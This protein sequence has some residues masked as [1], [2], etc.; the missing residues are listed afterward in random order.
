MVW[1]SILRTKEKIRRALKSFE[2]RRIEKQII[3]EKGYDILKQVH[4]S[5]EIHDRMMNENIFRELLVGWEEQENDFW[6]RF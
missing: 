4:E 6:G 2:F 5:Y 3:V 1:K